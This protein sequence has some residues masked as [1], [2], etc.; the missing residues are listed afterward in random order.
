MLS[1]QSDAERERFKIAVSVLHPEPS[2]PSLA[3]IYNFSLVG[4]GED[5]D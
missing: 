1:G 5:A 4:L 2:H 3:T